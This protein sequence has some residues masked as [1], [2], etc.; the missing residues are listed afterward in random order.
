M[1]SVL[2]CDDS[3]TMRLALRRTLVLGGLAVVGE[4]AT[5][6]EAVALAE[7]LKPDLI[8]MDVMLPD[9]DGFQAT[10]AILATGP[11]RIVIVSAAGEALQTDLSFRAL[12]CGALDLVE[13]PEAGDPA[14][15]QAWGRDLAADLLALAA[16]PVGARAPVMHS[17]ARPHLGGRK[18]QAF[19]I[20]VSTGGPPALASL[21]KGLAPTLSYPVLVA[22]H[23]APGF[24]NG[25]ASWLATQTAL[26]VKVAEG[27]ETA[28][29]GTVWLAR[30]R[31]DLLLQ[32][33]ARLRVVANPGGVCPNGDRLLA[34]VAERMGKDAAGAVLTG[35]GS[36]GA[37]G[38]LAMKQAGALTFAQ[39]SN[40]CA[41]D[42]M[43]ASAVALG[44]AEARLTLEELSFVMA[45]LGR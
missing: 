16:L 7:R 10:R 45:E 5:G 3:A 1:P 28:E 26:K 9:L 42:G 25:L 34:S 22:Q 4:A 21:L 19:G 20:A 12:Q 40:S 44:G 29:P 14:A 33:G 31:H 36:D 17:P 13:K 8:T 24:T 39:D 41:V 27:G 35:M 6:G 18:V 15:L 2:I 38:L 30:D 37:K 11:T 32:D 23:I 43:P